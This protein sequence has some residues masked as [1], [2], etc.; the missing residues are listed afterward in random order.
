[1]LDNS[2]RYP[3]QHILVEDLC[4]ANKLVGVLLALILTSAMA[5]IWMTHQT[6]ALISEN[7]QLVL[8]R[9]ALDNEYRN[10]QL[11]EVAESDNAHI[12]TIAVGSLKMQAPTPEQEVIIL[13]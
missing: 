1:M 9:Q 2:E 7:D 13:E 3:L 4:S 8:Q 11:Q 10:L 6:R 12:E 5:T